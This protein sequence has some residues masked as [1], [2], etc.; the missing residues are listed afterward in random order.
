MLKRVATLP[1]EKIWLLFDSEWPTALFLRSTLRCSYK[2]DAWRR[3]RVGSRRVTKRLSLRIVY[4]K[5]TA[6]KF[7]FVDDR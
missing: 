4:T 7:L 5:T 1:S 2:R 6:Q 3:C